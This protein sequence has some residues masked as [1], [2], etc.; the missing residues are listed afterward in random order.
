MVIQKML[1]ERPEMKINLVDK[2][3]KVNN[4]VEGEE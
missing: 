2:V 1:I 4:K 3:D